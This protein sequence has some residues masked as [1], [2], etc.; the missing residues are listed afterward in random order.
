MLKRGKQGNGIWKQDPEAS[1]WVQGE[2]QCEM[3]DAPLWGAS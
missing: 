2:W 1:I 3:E